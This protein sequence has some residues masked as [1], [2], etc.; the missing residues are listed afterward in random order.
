MYVFVRRELSN[1]LLAR[2]VPWCQF[3]PNARQ[4]QWN[5]PGH[6]IHE[7]GGL[8]G[9]VGRNRAVAMR[10]KALTRRDRQTSPVATPLAY[11]MATLPLAVTLAR[12]PC[13]V[14]QT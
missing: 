13:R 4:L 1:P 10:V 6:G 2:P 14:R 11:C 7:L 8:P 5:Q 12:L 9:I 3:Q